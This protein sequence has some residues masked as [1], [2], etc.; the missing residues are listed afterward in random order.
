MADW[1]TAFNWTMDFEDP[2]RAYLQT[3]DACPSAATG[4]CFA[5]GGV[6]SAAWPA[7]FAAIAAVPSD[8]RGPLV[9]T[10]YVKHFWNGYFAQLNSDDLCKRVFDFAVNGGPG[11]ALRCLQK[12]VNDVAPAG[13]QPLAVDGGWGPVTLAAANASDPVAAL[14]AF[15]N[16]RIAYCRAVVAT[17]PAKAKYL[18]GWIA[19]AQK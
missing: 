15:R 2:K 18:K 13:S 5:I 4:P 8:Q 19:R 1:N 12:A 9:Q 7:E 14:T 3:P 17:N 6:N 16:E 11:P 10:F